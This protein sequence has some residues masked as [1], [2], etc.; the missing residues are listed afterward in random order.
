MNGKMLVPFSGI[1]GVAL[2]LA[3]F[4]AAGS[5]PGTNA[6]TRKPRRFKSRQQSG[7]RLSAIL[8]SLGAL[9]FLIFVTAVT[10][11]LRRAEGQSGGAS[12][13]YFAGSGLLVV[14]LTLFAGLTLALGRV[15]DHAAPRLS[16]RYT[17][18]IRR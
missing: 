9:L 11:V 12:A 7:Q 3:S 17:Y 15:A 1:G 6:S 2:I 10:G 5:T 16:R 8:L 14:G 13:L 18:S 4:A